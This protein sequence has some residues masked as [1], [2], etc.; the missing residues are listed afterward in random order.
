MKFKLL[1]PAALTS[2]LLACFI[3]VSTP[4]TSAALLTP[5]AKN[6][7][8]RNITRITA[9]LLEHSQFSH[10]RLD[11]ELAAKFLDRYID[12]LDP[13]R[14]LFLQPDVQKFDLFHPHLSDLIRSQGDLVPERAIFQC[15]LDR[16]GQRV[17]YVTNLLHDEKF[18]FTGHDTYSFDRETAPRPEN[19]EA[20]H[21]L[22]REGLRSEYL[23]EKLAGKK[24]AEIVTALTTR[25]R[26]LFDSM[27]R[28]TPEEVLEVYLNALA[29][30]YDPH[31]DYFGPAQL[32]DFSITMNLSL[33]GIG[34]TLQSDDG[35]CKIFDLV[36]GGPAARSGLLKPGDRIV[37]VAQGNQKPV[38]IVDMPLSD[39]VKLIRG[40][41]GTQVNLTLIP[42]SATDESARKTISLVRDEVKL[43]DEQAKASIV[44]LP[45]KGGSALRMGV[46]DLPSFYRSSDDDGT[47]P[48]P[49]SAT[50]D[51]EKLINKLKAEHIQGLILD[52][53]H[54]GGG[55][56][57][58]AITLTS[59]FTGDGPVVQT[60]E[61]DG[62]TDVEADSDASQVYSGPLI[63][64]T[65]RFSA[66]AS[67][68]LAGA[69]QDYGRALIVGD[70]STF[71]KGTVQSVISLA[72]LMDENR[73]AHSSDP[74]AL[75]VTIRKFYRPSGAST[76]LKGVEA[77]IV[78]P[79][80]SGA[81]DVGEAELKDPLPWDS[82]SPSQFTR[83]DDVS[84]FVHQLQVLSA[85]R[86]AKDKDFSYLREDIAE[87]KK[88]LATKT[89]DLNEA[90]R[91]QEKAVAEA[92]EKSRDEERAA[93]KE[94]QPVIY[95]ITVQNADAPGLPAPVKAA[96]PV[97]KASSAHAG[98]DIPEVTPGDPDL[99]ESERI[100]ADYVGLIH[101]H[102]SVAMATH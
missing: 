35:Y 77:D 97:A 58:E 84:P 10:H 22:W 28:L 55:S 76:Q 20:A 86:I 40:P 48:T 33:F 90:D 82:I 87:L 43:E 85:E 95:D 19:L 21:Q 52:L 99:R 59:L 66:S 34:A 11:D 6:P 53:R 38:D 94:I 27:K 37:A 32:D 5:D 42:A 14:L 24:D 67:E 70:K 62:H 96:P 39:A 7:T 91:R 56:L 79:S 47:H 54:N 64:L 50:A 74:G 72:S 101:R 18:N 49:R 63:V 16:L 13:D 65:S 83:E 51:V 98:D 102:P 36:P 73:L 12:S 31:S 69:L 17:T 44:D 4:G 78:L 93:R 45:Q 23:Q 89:D 68:I 100:M 15:Y 46:I 75:K 8:D 88:N 80:L 3:T 71:G 92:R 57:E 29:H 41:K 9:E 60:R 26:R 25:Y 1:L 81:T 2:L 61:L 30:V